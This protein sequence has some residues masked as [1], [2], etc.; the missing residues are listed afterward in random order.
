MLLPHSKC[1]PLIY[2]AKGIWHTAK[3]RTLRHSLTCRIELGLSCRFRGDSDFDAE[4]NHFGRDERERGWRER[5]VEREREREA[6]G[7]PV[8]FNVPAPIPNTM[9]WGLGMSRERGIEWEERL[10]DSP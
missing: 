9:Q 10:R 8:L 3:T 5:P 6:G 7:E 2:H 4:S 1:S